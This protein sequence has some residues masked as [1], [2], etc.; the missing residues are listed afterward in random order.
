MSSSPKDNLLQFS[1][2][3]TTVGNLITQVNIMKMMKKGEYI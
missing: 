3:L 1:R 2:H